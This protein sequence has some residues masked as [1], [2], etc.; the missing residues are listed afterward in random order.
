MRI[1][2]LGWG[3]LIWQPK[4]LNYNLEHGWNPDGPYLPIEFSRISANGRLTLVIDKNATPVKTLFSISNY[5]ELDIA[6][7]DLAVREGCSKEKIGSCRKVDKDCIFNPDNFL[8]K[9]EI[10]KWL[11]LNPELD[12]VIWTN[13]SVKFKDAINLEYNSENVIKYLQA[14][15]KD[16]QV[17]A[18][19]Y[20]RK[21]HQQIQT[22]MRDIIEKTFNWSK[23]K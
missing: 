19:E 6:I 13:L 20:I 22:K 15:P 5:S 16:T 12:A 2:I 18:E 21:A 3:S 7:L 4:N 17:L 14:L 1:A 23:I 11:I 9:K 10:E 8:F